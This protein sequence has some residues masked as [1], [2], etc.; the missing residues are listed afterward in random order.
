[1]IVYTRES[2]TFSVVI[3]SYNWLSVNIVCVQYKAESSTLLHVLTTFTYSN[4]LRAQGAQVNSAIM[5][6]LGCQLSL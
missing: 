3:E 2:S 5:Y 6:M 4:K 1:M